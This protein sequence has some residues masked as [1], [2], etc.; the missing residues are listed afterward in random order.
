[1][2]RPT[3]QRSGTVLELFK[4]SLLVRSVKALRS[5]FSIGMVPPSRPFLVPSW[6][7]QF[8]SHFSRTD[9]G[10]V[11][12]EDVMGP[13]GDPH[14][15]SIYHPPPP[16]FPGGLLSLLVLLNTTWSGTIVSIFRESSGT[17][18]YRTD[19]FLWPYHQSHSCLSSI[20]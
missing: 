19:N 16:S 2:R 18:V 6:C 3:S 20:L 1:M 12:G 17:V 5:G 14:Q 13:G 9:D 4:S 10:L 11:S 8:I 7:R 15:G